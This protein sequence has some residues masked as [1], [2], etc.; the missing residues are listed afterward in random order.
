MA[1]GIR[2]RLLPNAQW[3]GD[4]SRYVPQYDQA[5]GSAHPD[6]SCLTTLSHG[7][8]RTNIDYYM[9]DQFDFSQS[10]RRN[11]RGCFDDA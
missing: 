11:H 7:K 3:I 10:P 4:P 2:S 5:D 8:I 9:N 6:L 1:V